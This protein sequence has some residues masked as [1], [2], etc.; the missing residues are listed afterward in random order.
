[1]PYDP[2]LPISSLRKRSA[3]DA[4]EEMVRGAVPV[5][6]RSWSTPNGALGLDT[7]ESF[8]A[9]EARA[10]RRRVESA[11][12]QDTVPKWAVEVAQAQLNSKPEDD[13]EDQDAEGEDDEDEDDEDAEGEDDPE[14]PSSSPSRHPAQAPSSR[15]DSDERW[16]NS[17]AES[18]VTAINQ[19]TRSAPVHTSRYSL[20]PRSDRPSL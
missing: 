14:E 11:S 15:R 7:G 1:M 17:G 5:V 2:S 13:G 8:A 18:Y 19:D 20:R 9:A 6:P 12:P 4:E 10:K 16:I 3:P